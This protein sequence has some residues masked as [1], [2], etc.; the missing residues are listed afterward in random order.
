MSRKKMLCERLCQGM[1]SLYLWSGSQMDMRPRDTSESNGMVRL[2]LPDWGAFAM[3]PVSSSDWIAEWGRPA[4]SPA[5]IGG[6]VR[7]L[8]WA[9]RRVRRFLTGFLGQN[10]I[11]AMPR[12]TALEYAST[13]IAWK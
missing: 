1:P 6:A 11:G 4:A 9:G 10:I 7:K 3:A 13:G 5:P 2:D 12:W 8:G